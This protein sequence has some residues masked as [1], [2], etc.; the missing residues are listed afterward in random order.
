MSNI[1]VKFSG[2][3][4]A[5]P[6][7][8]TFPDSG[9]TKRSFPV[10]VNDQDKDRDSGDYRDNGDVT[11]IRVEL[12]GD[13]AASDIRKGDIVEI[14]GTI[15]EKTFQKRD[16]SEGRAIQTKF[17]NSIVVKWRKDGAAPAAAAAGSFTPPVTSGDVW[18][19]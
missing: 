9:K 3:V 6:E 19:N 18:G 14:T 5:D 16:G 11:K 1:E 12:Y 8:Y 2:G 17:V 13:L 4:V 15:K 10:Y 7:D